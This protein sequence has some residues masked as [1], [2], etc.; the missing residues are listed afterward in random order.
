MMTRAKVVSRANVGEPEVRVSIIQC[1][2]VMTA[3]GKQCRYRHANA[4]SG[5]GKV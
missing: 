4:I 3:T 5:H 2:L 1:P